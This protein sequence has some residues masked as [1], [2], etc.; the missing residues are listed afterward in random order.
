MLVSGSVGFCVFD[1]DTLA[2]ANIRVAKFS[3]TPSI[4][5]NKTPGNTD[6]SSYEV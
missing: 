6:C 3:L 4:F 5:P 2:S 1:K